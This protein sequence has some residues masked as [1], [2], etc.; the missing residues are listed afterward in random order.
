[1]K[2]LDIKTDYYEC[3]ICGEIFISPKIAANH[4]EKAHGKPI[5][6]VYHTCIG[7][8]WLTSDEIRRGEPFCVISRS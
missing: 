4:A 6:L 3:P 7:D 1:M 2:R 8:F 5:R